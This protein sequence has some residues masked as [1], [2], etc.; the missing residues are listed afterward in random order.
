MTCLS[1]DSVFL[2]G[3]VPYGEGKGYLNGQPMV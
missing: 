2:N 3:L 1:N